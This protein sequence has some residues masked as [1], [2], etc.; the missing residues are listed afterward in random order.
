MPTPESTGASQLARLRFEQLQALV[1]TWWG[2]GTG[3][4]PTVED[5]AYEESLR[6]T[7]REEGPLQLHYEQQTWLVHESGQREPS[8]WETG[9]FSITDEGLLE[10]LN[11]QTSGRVEVLQGHLTQEAVG[12]AEAT[13]H[14]R[15]SSSLHGHDPRMRATT[16]RLWVRPNQLRYEVLMAT[17]SV[18]ELT[19]HLTAELTRQA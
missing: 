12:S 3:R 9:F 14:L 6:I 7:G 15:F 17:D 16:R 8:H 4:F 19:Q 11:A 13:L 5:F 1:G 2:S 10:V 18:P